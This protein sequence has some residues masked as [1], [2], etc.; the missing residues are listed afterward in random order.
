M[1]EKICYFCNEPSSNIYKFKKDINNDAE[2]NTLNNK[3]NTINYCHFICPECL[4]RLI[5]VKYINIF[6]EPSENYNFYCTCNEGK[7]NLSYLQLIDVFQK[8]TID[9]LK[10]KK[11]QKCKKHNKNYSKYCKDCNVDICEE[12][13]KES[14]K[15]H[16]NH[17]IEDKTILFEKL[18]KFFAVLNLRYY[19]FKTF[20]D[21]FNNICKK[22]KENL[23]SNFNDT[24]I[25]IDKILNDLIDFRAK[26]SVYYKEKI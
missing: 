8:K 10:K 3:N 14:Y 6:A 5:F 18:K 20:M 25:F 19:N 16:L 17:R 21:N 24:L 11:E 9:N 2:R 13:I 4:I 1:E 7:L 23:E 15:D 22:Y 26:I 12:C